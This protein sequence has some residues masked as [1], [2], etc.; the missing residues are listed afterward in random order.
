MH[1]HVIANHATQTN[2]SL[3]ANRMSSK[4]DIVANASY[5]LVNTCRVRSV[6]HGRDISGFRSRIVTA[7]INSYGSSNEN[8]GLANGLGLGFGSC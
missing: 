8:I 6:E 3:L 5:G 4:G 7:Q 1:L 2:S